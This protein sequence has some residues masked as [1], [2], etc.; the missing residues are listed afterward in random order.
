MRSSSFGRF[1]D[2]VIDCPSV[3]VPSLGAE[4]LAA[5]QANDVPVLAP[6]LVQKLITGN[7]KLG[8]I[9]NES[10]FTTGTGTHTL[11]NELIV[12]YSDYKYSI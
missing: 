1:T 8:V 6:D 7:T 4:R 10:G 9:T 3:P 12:S 2:P 11:Y 5:V